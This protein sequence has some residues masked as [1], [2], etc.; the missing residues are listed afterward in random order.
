[1]VAQGADRVCVVFGRPLGARVGRAGQEPSQRHLGRG[2]TRQDVNVISWN[3]GTDYLLVS[4]GDEGAL[5]VWDLRHFKPSS[6]PSPVAHFEWHKA[7]I[8]SVEWH[9]TEDSIFA[10]AGRDDQVTLWDLS[11]EQDDDETQQDGL[12]DVPPQLLFCHHGLTDCKELHWHP[13]IPGA[14]AT[15]A[16]DGFN[17]LKTISV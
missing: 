7:P 13:Q 10:A 9:P 1:M 4:G 15:T 11:V 17:I 16:L 6:T 14:L 12:R 8:S 5:K 3:R 2:R